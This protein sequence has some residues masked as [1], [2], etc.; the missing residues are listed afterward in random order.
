MLAVVLALYVMWTQSA[1][2]ACRQALALG[3]DVSGSVDSA[4]YALQVQGLAQALNNADVRAALLATPTVPVQL[5]IYEWS[6][7]E[8]QRVLVGWT[9]ITDSASLSKVT[10]AL[11]TVKRGE[12]PPATGLGQTMLFGAELLAQRPTCWKHTLDISGDGRNNSGTPPETA[13]TQIATHGYAHSEFL[14]K[15]IA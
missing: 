11:A 4:E 14:A 10:S 13:R 12:V 15:R 9:A 6:A 5:A 1:H 3:L 2:A 7:P 8:Y